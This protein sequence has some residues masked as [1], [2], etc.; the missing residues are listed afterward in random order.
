MAKSKLKLKAQVLRRGG[1]GIREI[2]A[3]LKIPL[4]TTSYW[5]RNIPLSKK[6]QQRLIQRQR[7]KAYEGRLKAAEILRSRRLRIVESLNAVGVSEIGQI[8]DREFFIAGAALYWGEGY[9]KQEIVGFT[10][11]DVEIMNF[12]I[13]WFKKF[14]DAT[15]KDFILRVSINKNH[16]DRIH[17]IQ[18]YWS[19][20]TGISLNQF[21]K[22]A[23][24]L[25]KQNKTY[26]SRKS[27]YGTLRVVLRKS[28][29]KHRRLMGWI[30]GLKKSIC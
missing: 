4:S 20:S 27:Y 8:N 1:R 28:T 9:K 24:I 29:A 21:I 18:K 26:A 23:L 11:G 13:K 15:N 22:P 30:G 5:C 12:A 25:A 19:R 14:L 2:V 6:Q 7:D 3:I 10:S 16:S 17:E